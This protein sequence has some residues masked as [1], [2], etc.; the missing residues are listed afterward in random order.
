MIINHPQNNKLMYTVLTKK[1][2]ACNANRN[3]I[4]VKAAEFE[5]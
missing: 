5:K 3:K 4:E 1:L 2:N